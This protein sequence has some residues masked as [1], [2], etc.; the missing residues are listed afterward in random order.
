MDESITSTAHATEPG[1]RHMLYPYS[2]EQQYLSGTLAYIDHAHR[3]GGTVVVAAPAQRREL[4]AAQLPGD[5]PV[6]F[7]DTAALGRN[8]GR[9]I[10]AWQDWIDRR[11]RDGRVHGV[12]ESVWSGRTSG[13]LA[14]LGYQ[15]WL[16]NLAFEHAPAWSLLCPYDTT[17]RPPAA[18]E[19]LTRC[20]PLVWDGA[21]D[22]PGPG[23]T[24]EPYALEPLGEPPGPYEEMH[25]TLG[26]LT[27]LRTKVSRLATEHRFARDRVGDLL[28][29]I[30]EI[31]G[32]SIR[33]GGGGGV[34]RVWT[35]GGE[36]VCELRDAGVITDPL[37]G[38]VRPS[39]SELG[40]RGLWFAQQV[41]D[42]VEIRSSSRDGTR[43]RLH[44]DL[45]AEARPAS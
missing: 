36:L 11:S 19:A 38:R 43:V 13:H 21:A 7:M 42:L 35:D 15:E 33:Y 28:L 27:A 45:P 5:A 3:V 12:N 37:L 41:C 4:L 18:V 6:A 29:A 14:E 22:V 17:G 32:N 39:P 9:L 16:L 44:M 8:P 30:S 25:Y 23:Y 24:A 40:G 10:P 31:A 20:H 1:L 26:D 2:G 34:L